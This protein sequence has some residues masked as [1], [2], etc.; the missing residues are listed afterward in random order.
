MFVTD[1]MISEM[2]ERYGVPV[3][4]QFD[5]PVT[6]EEFIR[7]RSSQKHGRNHDVTLYIF[8][9]DKIIVISKHMY[10]PN[11]FRAPSGG[12]KPGEDFETGAL[13]EAM[14]ETGCDV[15]LEKFLLM[16]DV[17]F[18]TKSN[19]LEWRSFIFQAQY[20]KGD[21]DFTD[22]NEIKEVQLASLAD[23][24]N[25]SAIMRSTTTGGLHYRAALHD[26]VKGLL[27]PGS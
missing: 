15:R 19:R 6:E 1:S 21:F 13:R 23:F 4:A 14:E 25:Y 26:A 10:P 3:R 11:L 22:H 24:E 2:Q 8:K 12:V 9:G 5:I 27:A 7:I 17:I 20:V 18:R 16:T